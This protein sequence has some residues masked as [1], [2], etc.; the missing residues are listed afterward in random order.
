M[1]PS[2]FPRGV[3]RNSLLAFSRAVQ[4]AQGHAISRRPRVWLKPGGVR[5]V[6]QMAAAD[7]HKFPSRACIREPCAGGRIFDHSH[8]RFPSRMWKCN[9]SLHQSLS[10]PFKLSSFPSFAL[11][12]NPAPYRAALRKPK[13][14]AVLLSPISS[15]TKPLTAMA[16][17]TQQLRTTGSQVDVPLHHSTLDWQ[18]HPG[19]EVAVTGDFINAHGGQIHHGLGGRSQLDVETR[20]YGPFQPYL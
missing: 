19:S 2:H 17:Q 11:Q 15:H 12:H 10:S 16:A 20:R 14:K 7:E 18:Y 13:L 6:T 5:N 8:N 9:L 1:V 3:G 4:Q